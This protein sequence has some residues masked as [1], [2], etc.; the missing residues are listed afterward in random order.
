MFFINQ[1]VILMLTIVI[2]T[3]N[4]KERLLQ[5]LKS[6]LDQ[7]SIDQVKIL[8]IDNASD[9][10]VQATIQG[11]FPVPRAVIEIIR[12]PYN[13]G[14]A[15]NLSS[16]FQHCDT[17]WCWALGDD[18]KTTENSLDIILSDINQHP[19]IAFT[20]YS[21]EG[22][23]PLVDHTVADISSF[24]EY[25]SSIASYTVWGEFTFLS[26]NLFN[27]AA[28]RPYLGYANSYSY[29][30]VG[31]L[32]PPLFALKERAIRARFSSD[33]IVKYIPPAPGSGW[34]LEYGFLGLTTGMHL[35]LGLE[36]RLQRLLVNALL[37]HSHLGYVRAML[38]SGKLRTLR[39][40][41]I[42]QHVY[43]SVYKYELGFPMKQRLLY[44]IMWL[45][46]LGLSKKNAELLISTLYVGVERIERA[47]SIKKIG[48]TG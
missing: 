1:D 28:L 9:Y 19:D 24:F 26:N 27:I 6:L 36:D 2:P 31:H 22:R 12:N 46:K 14:M 44:T 42:Y 23:V 38:A 25:Y 29:T 4:R 48:Y 30:Q 18:D 16:I 21:L 45:Y 41:S 34:S 5:Q 11:E 37:H 43:Q 32:I 15:A 3:Y 35:D 10:D 47:L 40:W 33:T 7:K 39:I 13:I 8:V 17:E 20:K